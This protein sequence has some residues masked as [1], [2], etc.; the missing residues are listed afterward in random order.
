[1]YPQQ[2]LENREQ[3]QPQQQQGQHQLLHVDDL[4]P[5]SEIE[6]KMLQEAQATDAEA[7]SSWG[8]PQPSMCEP[9]AE[10]SSSG[11]ASAA[12]LRSEQFPE[13]SSILQ[14]SCS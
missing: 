1:M 12:E 5:Y 11:T 8:E 7:S 6:F 2:E 3:P 10:Q 13:T 4:P 14:N 9:G